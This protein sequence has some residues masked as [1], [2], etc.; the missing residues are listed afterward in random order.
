MSGGG[1]R[2]KHF[3][4]LNDMHKATTG[5]AEITAALQSLRQDSGTAPG[6]QRRQEAFPTSKH[7]G[8]LGPEKGRRKGTSFL[9]H[10]ERAEAQR[11]SVMWP[12]SRL[13]QSWL[14][15]RAR[16]AFPQETRGCGYHRPGKDLIPLPCTTHPQE[17]SPG[18]L[19]SLLLW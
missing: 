10:K 12:M 15:S 4:S 17:L 16:R 11:G 1:G 18:D 7:Q 14:H 9:V 6:T 2:G 3:P 13:W 5:T 19:P 8:L